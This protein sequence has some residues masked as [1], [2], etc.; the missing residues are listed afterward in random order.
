VEHAVEVVDG[1]VAARIGEAAVD[2]PDELL[3][4]A[5]QFP[6]L[7]HLAAARHRD[8]DERDPPAQIV[9]LL[10]HELD[11]AQALDDPLRVIEPVDAEND[12]ALPK[13]GAQT[14]E[15]TLGRAR[16]SV[17]REGFGVDRDRMRGRPHPPARQRD[18]PTLNSDVFT[19]ARARA[20]EVVAVRVGLERDDV[21]AEQ[22]IEDLLAPRQP[23]V[24]LRGREPHVQEEPDRPGVAAAEQAR[25]Q[26]QVVVVHP[27]HA[28]STRLDRGEAF[29]HVAVGSPPAALED[30][31][32]DQ[33]VQQRPERAV[34]E[35]VV[36]VLDL[37]SAQRDGEEV[38]VETFDAARKLVGAAVPADPGAVT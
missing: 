24:D 38:D 20:H 10:E 17:L 36:V 16:A 11:R 7:A 3:D 6:V 26:H 33:P 32:L 37:A 22:P 19:K 5:P 27:P 29:V 12:A 18:R 15:A 23:G 34:R 30:R 35:A 13:L 21:G 25:Y 14:A 28:P 31:L 4:I 9:P 2:S 8:L 1:C